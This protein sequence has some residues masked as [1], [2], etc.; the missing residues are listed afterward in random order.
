MHCGLFCKH[1][2]DRRCNLITFNLHLKFEGADNVNSIKL[3][4]HPWYPM[5][6][7]SALNSLTYL[8]IEMMIVSANCASL[9]EQVMMV[10]IELGRLGTTSLL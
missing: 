7:S 8:Y 1:F 6:N 5:R 2:W 4:P 10:S 3:I 9:V